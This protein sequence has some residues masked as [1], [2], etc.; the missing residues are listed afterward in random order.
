MTFDLKVSISAPPL[1]DGTCKDSVAPFSLWNVKCQRYCVTVV[2]L[3]ANGGPNE[4]EKRLQ[5]VIDRRHALVV[6]R[7]QTTRHSAVDSE[8]AL[9]DLGYLK[10]EPGLKTAEFDPDRQRQQLEY[11]M[12]V[13]Q[14]ARAESDGK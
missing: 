11:K 8:L 7:S 9:E 3:I 2:R 5:V 13:L 6:Q 4:F 12:R 14:K 10:A 1:C